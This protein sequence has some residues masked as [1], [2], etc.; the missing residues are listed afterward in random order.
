VAVIRWF[1]RTGLFD[2]RNSKRQRHAGTN[3]EPAGSQPVPNS[4]PGRHRT[5]RALATSEQAAWHLQRQADAELS[6]SAAD[7]WSAGFPRQRR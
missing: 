7:L 4:Y 3:L 1:N 5:S 2:R 6:C